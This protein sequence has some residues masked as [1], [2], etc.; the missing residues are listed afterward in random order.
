MA[1]YAEP[2]ATLVTAD[3]KVQAVNLE[4]IPL[5]NLKERDVTLDPTFSIYSAGRDLTRKMNA[6]PCGCSTTSAIGI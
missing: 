2:A 6:T 1:S 5:K 3:G 4:V